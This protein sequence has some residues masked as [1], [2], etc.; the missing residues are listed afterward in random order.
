MSSRNASGSMFPASQTFSVPVKMT[1]GSKTS[2]KFSSYGFLL[3]SRTTTDP[4]GASLEYPIWNSGS[5]TLE[6]ATALL[7]YAAFDDCSRGLAI[8]KPSTQSLHLQLPVPRVSS[9]HFMAGS[10]VLQTGIVM[11]DERCWPWIL[12]GSSTLG[13][14]TTSWS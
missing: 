8:R 6:L 3:N 13:G 12:M 2:L 5:D 1:R 9:I 4:R 7:N 11:L 10:N 14:N